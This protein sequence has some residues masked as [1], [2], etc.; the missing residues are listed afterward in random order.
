MDVGVIAT[1]VAVVSGTACFFIARKLSRNRKE[2]KVQK[3]VAVAKSNESRQVR[4]ARERR[5]NR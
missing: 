4:R 3:E 1:A 2:K 5:E